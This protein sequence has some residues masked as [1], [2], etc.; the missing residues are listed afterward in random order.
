MKRQKKKDLLLF[1][2]NLIERVPDLSNTKE[3]FQFHL[4]WKKY[5]IGEKIKINY[6]TTK[7]FRKIIYCWHEISFYRTSKNLNCK[8]SKTIKQAGKVSQVNG[9]EKDSTSSYTAKQKKLKIFLMKR[10]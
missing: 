4:K 5:K 10:L 8:L 7:I 3:W 9:N 6:S 1:A 2:T